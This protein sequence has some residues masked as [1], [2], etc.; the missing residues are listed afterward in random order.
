MTFYCR[1]QTSLQSKS[2]VASHYFLPFL[3]YQKK[4][5]GVYLH[6]F[7]VRYIFYVLFSVFNAKMA[8]TVIESWKLVTAIDNYE[9]VAG[10]ILFTRYV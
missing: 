10:K 7:A 6:L 3:S 4:E 5:E 9:E 8:S 1:K 2:F